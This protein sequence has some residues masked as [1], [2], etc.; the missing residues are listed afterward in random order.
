MQKKV[1]FLK[2]L[3]LLYFLN[4]NKKFIKGAKF[5]L[6][7]DL[8][9]DV[10]FELKNNLKKKLLKK[11]EIN[12]ENQLF[13]N[14]Y[15]LEDKNKTMNEE[16]TK[17][18][19]IKERNHVSNISKYFDNSPYKKK[20]NQKIILNIPSSLREIDNIISENFKENPQKYI[21]W[22]YNYGT[23][24]KSIKTMEKEL[25]ELTEKAKNKYG[26]NF[27]GKKNSSKLDKIEKN[28][29][30]NFQP[31]NFRVQ[32]EL[33]DFNYFVKNK[34]LKEKVTLSNNFRSEKLDPQN[35]CFVPKSF[36]DII[37]NRKEVDNTFEMKYK[38]FSN[39]FKITSK[40]N[41]FKTTS[42]KLLV[43]NK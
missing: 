36:L 9:N 42:N 33:E 8:T 15:L 16:N 39:D 35:N 20:N 18:N 17:L 22:D 31:E 26:M 7:Q 38:T 23:S 32:S 37:A 19:L 30:I 24:N 27:N 12:T 41:M 34:N 29:Y 43:K 4:F 2:K 5:E 3:K 28:S 1:N 14:N 13:H 6:T 40:V 10:N 21:A 25:E 11:Q